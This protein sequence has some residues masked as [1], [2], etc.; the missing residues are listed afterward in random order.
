MYF[1]NSIFIFL[2]SIKL[3]G[4]IAI[5]RTIMHKGITKGFTFLTLVIFFNVCIT[6]IIETF[7]YVIKA[8]I[9][10]NI[11]K[12]SGCWKYSPKWLL[13]I[14]KYRGEIFSSSVVKENDNSKQPV[15]RSI[16]IA[17]ITTDIIAIF[18]KLSDLGSFNIEGTKYKTI[19][20][21]KDTRLHNPDTNVV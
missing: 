1:E 4:I 12:D 9:Q 19:N 10:T 8:K 17:V 18:F 15:A 13:E 11:N 3:W 16:K 14:S 2:T 20:P 5:I 6:S 7:K 21:L